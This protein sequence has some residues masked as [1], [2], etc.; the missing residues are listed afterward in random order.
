MYSLENIYISSMQKYNN[1]SAITKLIKQSGVCPPDS[2]PAADPGVVPLLLVCIPRAAALV[3][4]PVISLPVVSLR[5]QVI[6]SGLFSVVV[7][8]HL[9]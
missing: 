2:A 3:L 8:S 4:L 5:N 7:T 6:V 9:P 1:I